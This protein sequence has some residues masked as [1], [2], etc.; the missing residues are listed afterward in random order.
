MDVDDSLD[1]VTSTLHFIY[2]GSDFVL[3]FMCVCVLALN[4]SVFSMAALAQIPALWSSA[5][6]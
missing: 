3:L 1:N 6:N 2:R 4:S 5:V